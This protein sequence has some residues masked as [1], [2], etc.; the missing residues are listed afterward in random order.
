M[1]ILVQNFPTLAPILWGESIPQRDALRVPTWPSCHP[2]GGDLATI[3]GGILY[4]RYSKI[5]LLGGAVRATL[6]FQRYLFFCSSS[7]TVQNPRT[8]AE[9][10]AEPLRAKRTTHLPSEFPVDD[11]EPF[12]KIMF[13]NCFLDYSDSLCFF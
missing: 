9:A 7:T 11:L 3:L 2:V 12:Q 8:K 10:S 5:A 13:D 4:C 1:G 6:T